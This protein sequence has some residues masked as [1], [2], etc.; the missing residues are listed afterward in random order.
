M[1][2]TFSQSMLAL[3]VVL[4]TCLPVVA[5]EALKDPSQCTDQAPDEF[6]V[7]ITTSK[8]DI[9]IRV[10]RDWA[11]IGADRF[12][13]LVKHG[14]LTENR[15]FRIVPNFIVQFGLSGDPELNA[16]WRQ[17]RIKDDPG[18]QSNKRGTLTFATAGA[19]TRTTQL[20][21]NLVNN[22]SLDNRGFTPF[23]EVTEG[24]DV[25]NKLYQGYGER[26]QQGLIVQRGNAYLKEQFPD[27]DYIETTSIHVVESES[28]KSSD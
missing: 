4:A 8:G 23:G 24:M 3:G 25:V 10:H 18:T 2:T 16:V 14:Y 7:T 17:A 21:I 28:G 22:G 19:D 15:F 12:Y 27:L 5:D 13:N 6:D 11:P 26:P 9:V 20:F 1:K